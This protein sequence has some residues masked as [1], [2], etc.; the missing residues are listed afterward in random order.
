MQIKFLDL[1]VWNGGRLFDEM[2][3]FLK[4]EDPDILFLQEAYDG[5]NEALERCF[6]TIEIL[7][8]EL[9]YS[10]YHF[11]PSI[12][13]IRTNGEKIPEGNAIFSKY[14]LFPRAPIFFDVPFGEYSE[15]TTT[16]W[17]EWPALMQD[18]T[19]TLD[20]KEI[21]LY[22]I[23]G[24]W[25]LGGGDNARRLT[26]SRIVV[27]SVKDKPYVILSGDT[28]VR[29]ETTTIQNI[30]KQLRNVFKGEL[31]TSFN[32][33]QKTNPGYAEAVVDHLLVSSDIKVLNHACPQV[34]ISDHL[35]LVAVLKI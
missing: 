21:H 10:Y 20:G 2:L 11:D 24:P 23:H 28:N 31:K 6:R 17:A 29:P 5:K 25:G 32:M 35:P 12:L 16:N 14:P 27:E 19:A 1:N 18:V 34:N 13:D 7:K 3:Q 33:Q 8:K 26:M 9:Q 30:E 15:E 4:K 22:N